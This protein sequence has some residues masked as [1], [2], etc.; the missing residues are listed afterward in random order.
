M[1]T[2]REVLKY[3][4][5][6]ESACVRG[7]DPKPEVLDSS[8]RIIGLSVGKVITMLFAALIGTSAPV[9][10]SPSTNRERKGFSSLVVVASAP[11][12]RVSA[13]G[14]SSVRPTSVVTVQPS[15]TNVCDN[16]E[17]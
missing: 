9:G 16:H 7:I 1:A 4:N 11:A 12:S 2:S 10:F 5:G 13:S 14:P 15:G 17:R 3:V 8:A 6:V